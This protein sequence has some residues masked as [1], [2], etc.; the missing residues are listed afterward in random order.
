MSVA[1]H[2][3]TGGKH[4]H[5]FEFNTQ[6]GSLTHKSKTPSLVPSY[7]S[8]LPPQPN[9]DTTK[10]LAAC[11][12]TSTGTLTLYKFAATKFSPF[13]FVGSVPTGDSPCFVSSVVVDEKIV[14]GVANY[15][16]GVNFLS[17][18][19]GELN[20]K[21]VF[22]NEGVVGPNV[23]R[24][25]K[26]HPH[27]IVWRGNIGYVCD[28]GLDEIVV[29]KYENQP[30]DSTILQKFKCPPGSG[31]RHILFSN[32]SPYAYI[33]NELQGTISTIHISPS[34]E[35]S[36]LV[37]STSI[38][39]PSTL[40]KF[41]TTTAGIKFFGEEEF[42]LVSQRGENPFLAVLRVGS[43]GI[44]EVIGRTKVGGNVPR[45]FGVY[46]DFVVVGVQDKKLLE[47]YLFEREKVEL[48]KVGEFE[49]E[50]DPQCILF[51]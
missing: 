20:V 14:V 7:I 39:P 44:V 49:M 16:G 22:V 40:I 25:E 33:V 30:T 31:P 51:E 24:Q 26:S 15:H 27:Q 35:I 50:N 47:V 34:G 1:L 12:E 13:E 17:V 8:I 41:E 10:Y 36:H 19:G 48:R 9:S 43:G 38:L 21:S 3:G 23:E 5:T 37:S 4:I 28:L 6:T 29:L 46:G 11:N 32:K 45:D 18:E 42:I 2:V